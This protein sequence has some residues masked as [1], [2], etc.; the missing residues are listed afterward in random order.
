LHRQA[1]CVLKGRFC[2]GCKSQ[3]P[4]QAGGVRPRLSYRCLQPRALTARS[5]AQS[6][7]LP[8]AVS[9]CTRGSRPCR[10]SAVKCCH[11]CGD[12]PTEPDDGGRGADGAGSDSQLS[13]RRRGNGPAHPRVRLGENPLGPAELW[14]QLLKTSVSL[15][16]GSRHPMWIG[17]GTG[18]TFLYND[19]YLHV[20]GAVKHHVLF[21]LLLPHTPRGWRHSRAVLPLHG[22]HPHSPER[23]AAAHAFRTHRQCPGRED[24]RG[25]LRQRRRSALSRVSWT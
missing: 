15:I 21:V 9:S 11:I 1:W 20:L 14:P 16:L 23:E 3:C 12:R 2:D 6:L 25:R 10:V 18:M 13:I 22:R 19:A 7:A 8:N 17:W 5:P 4:A 24:H